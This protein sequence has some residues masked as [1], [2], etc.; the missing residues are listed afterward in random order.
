VLNKTPFGVITLR[1][2]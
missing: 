2:S 1:G